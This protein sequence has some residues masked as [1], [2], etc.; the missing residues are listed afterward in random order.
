M[1]NQSVHLRKIL[2][3]YRTL[4]PSVHLCG[5]SQFSW[6]A[7][8]GKCEFQ[9]KCIVDVQIDDLNWADMVA[10]VRGDALLD[11]KIAEICNRAN[12]TLLYILDD[13]LLNVPM[14]LGSGPY[15]RQK[16]VKR[17][18]KRMM[19]H[20]DILLS[21]SS[22]LLHKYGSY[23]EK[24]VQL[25]EP[26]M[27]CWDEKPIHKD[28]R[29]HLGFAGSFDRQGDIDA[30]LSEALGQIK[31]RYGDLVSI[32]FFGV[33]PRVANRLPCTVY[34]YQHSYEEYQ[35]KMRELN[36]DIGLAPM[37]DTEFHSCKHFNK[38]V[39]YAGF[40]VCGIY[41]DVLPYKGAVLNRYNGLLCANDTEAWVRAISILIEDSAV[42]RNISNNCLLQAST[43]FSVPHAAENLAE[44]LLDFPLRD[45]IKDIDVNLTSIK[46]M[47]SISWYFEK[48]KKYGWR[49]PLVAVQKLIRK[50]FKRGVI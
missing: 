38:L 33:R 22:K 48:Y 50:F 15:Y 7:E 14:N 3:L 9:H 11:E 46:R 37:P 34:P 8:K 20:C 42:R 2:L 24:S 32:E 10:F 21:P 41:S 1:I 26:S 4:D 44:Q 45:D 5:Y 49:T 12:K 25:I 40:G 36:W 30:I 17:H 47:G 19:D 29:I 27:F 31:E 6:L 35:N 13:D 18:I 39:E 16:S 43:E 23:F 28:G